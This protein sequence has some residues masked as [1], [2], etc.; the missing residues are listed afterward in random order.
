MEVGTGYLSTIEGK[1]DQVQ[2]LIFLQPLYNE[3]MTLF[4]FLVSNN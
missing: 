3:N 1:L 2:G 4:F